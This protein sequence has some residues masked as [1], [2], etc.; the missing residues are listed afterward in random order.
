MTTEQ[1]ERHLDFARGIWLRAPAR[2]VLDGDGNRIDR[3]RANN[4]REPLHPDRTMKNEST[5]E[6]KTAS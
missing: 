1:R 2:R 5:Q 3:R 6:A 4:A